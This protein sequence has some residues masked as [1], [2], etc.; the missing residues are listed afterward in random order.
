MTSRSRTPTFLSLTTCWAAVSFNLIAVGSTLAFTLQSIAASFLSPATAVLFASY[1]W[2]GAPLTLAVTAVVFLKSM[3]T[4]G[5]GA[6]RSG[7]VTCLGVLALWVVMLASQFS[8][9]D[10]G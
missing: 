6:A 10:R 8:S 3:M 2:F 5:S 9:G 4:E 1:V 7:F